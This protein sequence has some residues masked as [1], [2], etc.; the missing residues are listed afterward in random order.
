MYKSIMKAYLFIFFALLLSYINA[1]HDNDNWIKDYHL[2]RT[3]MPSN[4][5]YSIGNDSEDSH[6]ICTD[7]G[8]NPE[9]N[10]TSIEADTSRNLLNPRDLGFPP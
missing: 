8:F 5:I 9:T 1:Q 7:G 3:G 4:V 6:W 10:N 2:Y